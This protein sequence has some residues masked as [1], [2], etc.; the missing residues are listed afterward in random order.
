MKTGPIYRQTGADIKEIILQRVKDFY[1]QN[2]SQIS[3][4]EL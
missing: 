1:T 2:Q 3:G 4:S